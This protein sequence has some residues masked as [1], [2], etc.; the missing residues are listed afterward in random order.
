MG[1]TIWQATAD[2]LWHNDDFMKIH[3][4]LLAIDEIDQIP[5][6]TMNLSKIHRISLS[7]SSGGYQFIRI[8]TSFKFIFTGIVTKFQKQC[9][10]YVPV[11]SFKRF[12]LI[13]VQSQ[14]F[15]AIHV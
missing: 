8:A 14:R 5:L 9:I 7:I 6:L 11:P 4:I 13:H 12:H 10:D 1:E 2:A 3:E 15:P